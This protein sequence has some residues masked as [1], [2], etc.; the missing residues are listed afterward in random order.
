MTI[1]QCAQ[2]PQTRAEWQAFFTD[3]R[4]AQLT[5]SQQRAL[6]YIDADDEDKEALTVY[7]DV[8]DE[9][10]KTKKAPKKVKTAEEI[11]AEIAEYE[12]G[13][14]TKIMLLKSALRSKVPNDEEGKPIFTTSLTITNGFTHLSEDE[15]KNLKMAVAAISKYAT[16]IELNKILTKKGKEYK[17]T[18]CRRTYKT[19]HDEA[20]H[21]KEC[22]ALDS[23]IKVIYG[24]S[25]L[26]DYRLIECD[27]ATQKYG[28]KL[29]EGELALF[30][31]SNE[32]VKQMKAKPCLRNTPIDKITGCECAI[33]YDYGSKIYKKNDEGVYEK[34][35]KDWGCIPCNMKVV[36]GMKIC[37]RHR[38]AL[39]G[40]EVW[41]REALKVAD[42]LIIRPE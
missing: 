41:T 4:V 7:G 19:W 29:D 24:K 32:E 26:A 25:K 16:T 20:A 17:P 5:K 42:E 6:N 23:T 18:E 15:V 36:D 31:M 28:V 39:K 9:L 38:N 40:T 22:V 11:S 21:K 37:I 8:W 12:K 1:A 34:V 35:K 10:P 13:I 33:K 3:E 2:K 14:F 27:E 30:N